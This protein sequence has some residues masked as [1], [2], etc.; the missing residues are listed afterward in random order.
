MNE[1]YYCFECGCMTSE[2]PED[3]ECSAECGGKKENKK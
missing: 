1:D 3:C 2:C